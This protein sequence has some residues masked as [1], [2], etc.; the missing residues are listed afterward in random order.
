MCYVEIRLLLL[1]TLF[2]YGVNGTGNFANAKTPTNPLKN[3]PGLEVFGM[4]LMETLD[5]LTGI[6]KVT[7]PTFTCDTSLGD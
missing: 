5:Q 3:L 2:Y 1:F 6:G 4:L 7:Y